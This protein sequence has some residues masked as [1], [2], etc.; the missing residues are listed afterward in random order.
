MQNLKANQSN[1]PQN[2]NTLTI[3]AGLH[4]TGTTS[5]QNYLVTHR[6]DLLAKNIAYDTTKAFSNNQT[7][8]WKIR[9]QLHEA[10]HMIQPGIDHVIVSCEDIMLEIGS[11]YP[12]IDWI[13]PQLSLLSGHFSRIAIAITMPL[14][15][16]SLCKKIISQELRS[17]AS[18]TRDYLTEKLVNYLNGVTR[19]LVF[20]KSSPYEV[21]L[22]F[23]EKLSTSGNYDILRPFINY[24]NLQSQGD[25]LACGSIIS[26][27][28][29]QTNEL[30]ASK[31]LLFGFTR[32]V[33]AECKFMSVS[34]WWSTEVQRETE[35][36]FEDF[37]IGGSQFIKRFGEIVD[38]LT[39]AVLDDSRV[40]SCIA[41]TT[42]AYLG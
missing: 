30:E 2:C 22:V 17:T 7:N 5:I 34:S 14:S 11:N 28:L 24:I 4:K 10:I 15:F 19:S 21:N 25:P 6:D 8:H 39:S 16:Q 32:Q 3:H 42:K 40:V 18:P 37:A 27:R 31:Y 41:D 13:T 1:Q 9:T 36:V 23:P 33:I 12:A 20:L 29:N 38:M 35:Y 26:D